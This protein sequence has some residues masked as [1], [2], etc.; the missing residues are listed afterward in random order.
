MSE[1]G[2]VGKTV[3]VGMMALKE[4][5]LCKKEKP[6]LC[7]NRSRPWWRR[8]F[9]VRSILIGLSVIAFVTGWYFLPQLA[10]YGL[11]H[12]FSRPMSASILHFIGPRAGGVIFE[13]WEEYYPAMDCDGK[14][15][16]ICDNIET[17]KQAK[18][19]VASFHDV[20]ISG[21]DGKTPIDYA[22]SCFG[23]GKVHLVR[24]L[25]E[26]GA[27]VDG[28]RSC[29]TPLWR[30][31][32]VLLDWWNTSHL[33]SFDLTAEQTIRENTAAVAQYLI[34]NGADIEA[35]DSRGLTV[36]MYA[37]LCKFSDI[38]KLLLDNG[39]D[40]KAK[41]PDTFQD[42]RY[43]AR[44]CSFHDA[45]GSIPIEKIEAYVTEICDILDKHGLYGGSRP[46]W[47]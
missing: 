42:S 41:S 47:N 24:I 17:E 30:L 22:V 18:R 34:Q 3:R 13:H 40:I 44:R 25:I 21:P 36:L 29:E 43:L 27:D 12:E 23:K 33:E 32:E 19:F 28:G 11:R 14:I 4:I 31:C 46:L 16:H 7:E 2:E 6:L 45:R 10:G 20:N 35:K 38:V 15:K 1:N 9:G 39:A 5:A 8:R 37:S 26:N